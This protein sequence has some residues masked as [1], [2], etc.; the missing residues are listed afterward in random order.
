M[1]RRLRRRR[2]IHPFQGRASRG[3]K[4]VP[5]PWLVYFDAFFE[6]VAFLLLNPSPFARWTSAGTGNFSP[7]PFNVKNPLLSFIF[8]RRHTS[9]AKKETASP[10]RAHTCRNKG[11]NSFEFFPF[12]S[13]STDFA[14]FVCASVSA[15][16]CRQEGG[17][18]KSLLNFRSRSSLDRRGH[19]F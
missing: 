1:P 12:F 14:F 16:F 17:R 7:P 2:R 5:S 8:P 11:E 4:P 15:L 18:A 6:K 3:K 9:G 13:R 10:V 19:T